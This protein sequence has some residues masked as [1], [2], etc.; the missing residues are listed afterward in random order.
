MTTVAF[1]GFFHKVLYSIDFFGLMKNMQA[2]ITNA[3]NAKNGIVTN[4]NQFKGTPLT[5]GLKPPKPGIYCSK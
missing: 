4:A 3:T 5:H 2:I 1:F